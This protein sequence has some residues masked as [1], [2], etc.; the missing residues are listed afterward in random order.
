M[1]LN[2]E[3]DMLAECKWYTQSYP[4][5]R[6]SVD[7]RR[8]SVQD[9]EGL[10]DKPSTPLRPIGDDGSPPAIVDVQESYSA[11]EVFLKH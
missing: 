8:P 10:I 3:L 7:V 6:P 5:R 2:I 9:L 1:N 11:V 4:R